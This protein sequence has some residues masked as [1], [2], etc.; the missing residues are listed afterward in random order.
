MQ[1]IPAMCDNPVAAHDL[2]FDAR[3]YSTIALSSALIYCE[4]QVCTAFANGS[5]FAQFSGSVGLV[6]KF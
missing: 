6:V 1:I 3:L 4:P 5:V 2:R